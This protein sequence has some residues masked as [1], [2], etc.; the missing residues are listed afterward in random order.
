MIISSELCGPFPQI[1]QI[2]HENL[3]KIAIPVV[4]IF[5]IKHHPFL[6]HAMYIPA[7]FA[8]NDRQ[9]LQKLIEANNFGTLISARDKR[10]FATHLPFIY[11]A[12]GSRLL[13]H[14]ARANPHWQ[15]LAKSTREALVIFQGPHAY[16]S[17]SLYSDPGVPTWNYATVHVYGRF[18]VLEDE[19]DHRRV[20][21]LLTEQHEVAREEPWQVDFDASMVQQMM[22]ATVAF[23]IIIS[24]QQGKF[25]LSQNRSTTDRENVIDALEAEGHENS[26]GLASLM[27]TT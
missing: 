22:R 7:H 8:E 13:G 4:T 19:N 27:R 14:M 2:D 3:P 20:L 18:R 11:D 24:E 26:I 12:A 21:E 17:P 10:P 5:E 6:E 16:I 9:S 25:K 1:I 23:E 15:S